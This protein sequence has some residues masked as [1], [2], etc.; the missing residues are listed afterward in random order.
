MREFSSN[1]LALTW[2]RPCSCKVFTRRPQS[3]LLLQKR[4]LLLAL[5][6]VTAGISLWATGIWR[7]VE[8]WTRLKLFWRFFHIDLTI[9]I[10]K[11]KNILL[12]YSILLLFFVCSFDCAPWFEKDDAERRRRQKEREE[13]EA[14][15]HARDETHCFSMLFCAGFI[16]FCLDLILQC[17]NMFEHFWSIWVLFAELL[18]L[19]RSEKRCGDSVMLLNVRRGLE[20]VMPLL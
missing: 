11:M 12:Q 4:S 5:R 18:C 10:R 7:I 1:Y 13:Q 16:C 14:I 15:G 6:R 20:K 17:L 2:S 9:L 8:R 19:R 3:Q